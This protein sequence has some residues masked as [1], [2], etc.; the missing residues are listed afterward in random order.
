MFGYNLHVGQTDF[1]NLNISAMYKIRY[2]WYLEISTGNVG[3]RF[4]GSWLFGRVTT[5]EN[6]DIRSSPG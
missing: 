5:E 3:F 4:V 6:L 1:T 2:V